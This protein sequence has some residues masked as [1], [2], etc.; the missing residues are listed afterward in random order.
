MKA[1][2]LTFIICLAAPLAGF[3]QREASD[4]I[5]L[6]CDSLA[7]TVN[8]GGLV[9][10]DSMISHTRPTF[11]YTPMSN[12]FYNHSVSAPLKL[13]IPDFTFAPGQ[14]S[15]F[16]WTNGEFI[17]SGGTTVYPG[18]MQIDCG[19]L[20]V[21]H[22]F[23]NFDLYVGGRVNKYGY[24]R[25]VHTQYGV[26]GSVTYNLSPTTSFTA[27]GTYYSGRLPMIGGGLPMP[28]AMVGYYDTSKFGGYVNQSLG[29]RFGVLVGGQTVQQV[30]TREYR[31]EPIVTP[32]VKVGTG[33]KKVG[34]GLPVGQIL[35]G[36]L[37]R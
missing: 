32:Y 35:H 26:D 20:G 27:F 16:R 13:N 18:L 24:F 21:F 15:I 5:S 30:Y 12:P 17:A 2:I 29:E 7:K 3:A 10:R 8:I 22:R 36:I 9:S 28:P 34:I 25:G 37:T 4:T 11:P 33:K 1:Y 31:L 19:A 23:G 6:R 14:A